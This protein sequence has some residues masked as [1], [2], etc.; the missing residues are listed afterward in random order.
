MIAW[1]LLESN[2]KFELSLNRALDDSGLGD[3]KVT[4]LGPWYNML[5]LGL[6]TWAETPEPARSD[7]HAWSGKP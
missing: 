3:L 4:Q 5:D 6:S 7:C 2:R 1:L